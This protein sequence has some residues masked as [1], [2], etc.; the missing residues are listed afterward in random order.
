MKVAS[1]RTLDGTSGVDQL[2]SSSKA[3]A[4]APRYN[5]PSWI[6]GLLNVWWRKFGRNPRDGLQ[7]GALK[8]EVAAL[9]TLD[10]L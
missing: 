10:G 6:K 7:C 5:D 2:V 4:A 8:P 3:V 9:M 1:V